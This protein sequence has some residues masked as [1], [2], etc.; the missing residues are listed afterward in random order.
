MFAEKTHSFFGRRLTTILA[1]MTIEN[2]REDYH[3]GEIS[4][5]LVGPVSITDTTVAQIGELLGAQVVSLTPVGS[6]LNIVAYG[7]PFLV[8]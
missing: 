6:S 4:F 2:Y 5:T 1:G 7:V 8:H 3:L